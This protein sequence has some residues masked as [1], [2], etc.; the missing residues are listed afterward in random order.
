[1]LMNVDM[2]ELCSELRNVLGKKP[3]RLLIV[4]ING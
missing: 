1:M 4:A 2:L 3:N